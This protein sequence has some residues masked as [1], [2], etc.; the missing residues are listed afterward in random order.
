MSTV[1]PPLTHEQI[2]SRLNQLPSLP[3]AVAELLASMGNEDVD[4]ERIARLIAKDQGLAARVLRVANS[5]FYGL[6]KRV[7]SINDAVVVLGFRAVRSMVL[8][9][10]ING[11]L[12]AEA[13]TG[14]DLQAYLRHGVGTALA[15]RTLAPLV[16]QNPDYAFTAGLLHDIGQLVLAAN[17]PAQ[18]TATLAYRRQH[19]CQLIIA[20]RDILGVDH[21][22]VGG[23]L[24]ETWHFPEILRCA[25]VDH[26]QPA[27]AEARSLADLIHLADITAHAL[28]LANTPDEI[29]PPVDRTAWERLRLDTEKY[30]AALPKIVHS[31][32]ETCQAL[33]S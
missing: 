16:G 1:V 17:F 7:S 28:G 26:H 22:Q 21:P 8:A 14:F 4:V 15:A 13:C 27:T 20:E 12:R 2:R 30:A 24:A 10:S 6:Q 33:I 32:E 31:M 19:D 29:V 18:Y 23:M 25:A 11:A 9:I 3:T 5:S